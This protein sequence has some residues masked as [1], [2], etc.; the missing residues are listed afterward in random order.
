MSNLR[1]HNVDF[2]A[3]EIRLDFG[4]T[5]NEKG[6]KRIF[7]FIPGLEEL[8]YKQR[9]HTSYIEKES[10]KL[11]PCVFHRNGREIRAF[12]KDWYK[13]MK[14]AGIAGKKRHDFRST[15]ARNLLKLGFLP[16]EVCRMV[17][18]KSVEM[19]YYY[20]IIDTSDLHE[21]AQKL[22]ETQ[23]EVQQSSH[24]QQK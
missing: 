11:I 14:A 17:G 1:W 4:R 5:K 10:G 13:A 9:D 22:R 24:S 18:W 12:N 3:R 23:S 6:E 8:L 16:H 19:L 21:K 15:A 2:E 7:P 20:A